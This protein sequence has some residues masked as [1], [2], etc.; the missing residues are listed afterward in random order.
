MGYFLETT[1]DAGWADRIER[2]VF[3]AGL[4]SITKDFRAMQYFSCPN[5]F[6][7]TG[8]SDHNA[9]KYGKTWMQ[10]RPI[11]ETEC[12]IGNIHR[13]FRKRSPRVRTQC[14]NSALLAARC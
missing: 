11:H 5:Q 13:L 8:S 9:F 3:N 6:L 1:G 4:G 12:C 7:A 14:W 10:Y 2:C